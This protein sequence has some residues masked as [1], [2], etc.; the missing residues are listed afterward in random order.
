MPTK[1]YTARST[2]IPGYRPGRPKAEEAGDFI[3]S[4]EVWCD[5]SD[6]LEQD[7]AAVI[8]RDLPSYETITP[9]SPLGD[10]NKVLAIHV[11]IVGGVPS[12]VIGRPDPESEF[13]AVQVRV[14]VA[15]GGQFY[16][17][18]RIRAYA[19]RNLISGLDNSTIP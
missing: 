17:V 2:S 12:N 11:A 10:R 5:S 4:Y 9:G 16:K 8:E 15:R 14:R 1:I 7:L 6:E 18:A 13:A 19:V 3:C